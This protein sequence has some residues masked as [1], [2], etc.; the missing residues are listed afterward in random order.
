MKKRLFLALSLV[1]LLSCLA[2]AKQF[3]VVSDKQ[4][5]T[6][7]VKAVDLASLLSGKTKA[8]VDGR[9]VRIVLRDPTLPD[10]EFVFRRVLNMTPNQVRALMQAH[11]GL[12]VIADTDDAVL[13]FVAATRGALGIVDLYSLTKDI[14]V[15][16]IDGKLP[17]D[18]GYLLKVD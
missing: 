18:T 7:N 11:P 12:I 8:W 3:A 15:I 16:K 10:M 17:F 5:T 1:L 13:R 14:A 2:Q 4:N 9:P 6:G